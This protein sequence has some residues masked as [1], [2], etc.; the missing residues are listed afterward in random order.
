MSDYIVSG[1]QRQYSRLCCHNE[2]FGAARKR[3]S[4]YFSG[5]I[6]GTG[7]NV[8]GGSDDGQYAEGRKGI[9]L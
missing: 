5:G 7:Q 3:D 4:P 6:R 1:R 8:D 2:R 9:L